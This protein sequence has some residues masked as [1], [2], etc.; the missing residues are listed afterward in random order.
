MRCPCKLCAGQIAGIGRLRFLDAVLS[1]STFVNALNNFFVLYYFCFFLL[2]SILR[3]LELL[4]INKI[5]IIP[6]IGDVTE[7]HVASICNYR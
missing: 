5:C 4:L 6:F 2:Y 3:V 1:Y 7:K